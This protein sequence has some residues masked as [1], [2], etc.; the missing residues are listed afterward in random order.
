[1][2][3]DNFLFK[4][5]VLVDTETGE[6]KKGMLIPFEVQDEYNL[7]HKKTAEAYK[8]KNEATDELNYFNSLNGSKYTF[9]VE[10]SVIELFN[11]DAFSDSEKV[12]IMY[13][14]SFVNYDGYL[15]SKK[16]QPIKKSDVMKMVQIRNRARFYDFYNK[17]VAMGLIKEKETVKVDD[18]GEIKSI[19]RL[20]WNTDLS[21]KGSP[22]SN[23]TTSYKVIRKYDETIQRLYEEN[24][25]KSL[26]VIFKILPYLN[27]FHNVLCKDTEATDYNHSQ[28]L[29]VQEVAVILGEDS[30]K[31]VQRK[32]LGL[33][34]GDEYIFSIR[35]TGDK[36]NIIVNPSLVW[37]SSYPPSSNLLGD[38]SLAK[39][40]L[41]EDRQKKEEALSK[42]S[43]RRS[44]VKK[45]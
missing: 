41:L 17:L 20:Y 44:F 34:V 22:K 19:I 23:G 7:V 11:N 29:T 6:I 37:L 39:K 32:L 28:P 10:R 5:E 3:K 36:T 12:H 30:R 24:T 14:G 21:F 18:N 16:N 40:Q 31:F 45:F 33:R 38:F 2:K 13:L 26:V 43:N 42:I 15:M 1:M 25:A 4:T 9:S 27:K 35:K 8:K